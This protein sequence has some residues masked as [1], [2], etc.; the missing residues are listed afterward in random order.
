MYKVEGLISDTGEDHT[1]TC[2]RQHPQCWL[3]AR[4][5]FG[6]LDGRGSTLPHAGAPLELF[7]ST[8]RQ[9]FLYVAVDPAR[10]L[11]RLWYHAYVPYW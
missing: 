4:S 2:D 11:C 9:N 1:M 5:Q 3:L 6:I 10:K 8:S 7:P